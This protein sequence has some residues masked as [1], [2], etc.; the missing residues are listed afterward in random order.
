[1]MQG[2]FML[3][4]PNAKIN[5]GLYVT[6]R[7]KDGYHNLETVFFPVPVHDI[8]E[9]VPANKATKLD[10]SGISIPGNPESNLVLKAW[11]LLKDDH[12]LPD[13]KINLHKG[14]PAGAG[15]GGGSADAACC[16]MNLNKQFELGLS[17]NQLLKY[18]LMLGS[19][20]PF[21][22]KNK[23]VFATGRGEIMQEIPLN[24]SGNY[25]AIIHPDIHI[26]T[27]SAFARI[28]PQKAGFDLR[29]L[30]D[31]PKNNWKD[32]LSN[33]FELYAFEAHPVLEEIKHTLLDAG[34]WY[35]QMSG[36][37]SSVYGLFENQPDLRSGFG[38]MPSE[39]IKL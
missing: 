10:T 6:S 5:I 11:K 14:I 4:F 26:N 24:L 12:K 2:F 35:A 23:P 36:S 29:S 7:R 39:L 13:V 9:V 18:A 3:S 32:S 22:I 28:H 38:S 15:L 16:L 30:A 37:G 34:A 31:L 20:C 1:M 8:L 27:G 21:F 25:L 19:D 33:D 17:D